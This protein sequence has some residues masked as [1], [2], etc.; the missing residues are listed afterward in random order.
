LLSTHRDAVGALVSPSR[1]REGVWR[2]AG[3][4]VL[5]FVLLAV[6][7]YVVAIVA[8]VFAGI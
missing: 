1:R 3:C 6:I 5:D 7:F 4:M 8:S 2:G